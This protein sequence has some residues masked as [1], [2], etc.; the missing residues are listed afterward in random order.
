MQSFLY[1]TLDK[2]YKNAILNSRGDE[3]VKKNVYSITL[4]EDVVDAVDR[5]AYKNNMTRSGFINAVLAEYLGLVTPEV[6]RESIFDHISS[7]LSLDETFL[8]YP[9]SADSLFT[10]KSS[11]RFK[12]NPTIRYSVV[13][14]P[15]PEKFFGEL[16]VSLRTQNP[17]LLSAIDSFLTLWQRA[18]TAYFGEVLSVSDG[19]RFIRKLRTPSSLS[20]EALGKSAAVYIK[21]FNDC[22]GM[23]FNMY[24]D[25][26]S[27]AEYISER[28]SDYCRHSQ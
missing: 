9:K 16:R 23:H 12:Y 25:L 4:F 17:L 24:P 21:L 15:S 1:K 7:L 5:A 26:T 6:R 13:I 18:E 22:L 28:L 10:A 11:I 27:S 14:Y 2:L 20:P 19:T 8:V 3:V